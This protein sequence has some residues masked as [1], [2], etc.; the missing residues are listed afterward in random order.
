MDSSKAILVWPWDEAP[1][2]LKKIAS[3][4]GDEDW[5]IFVPKELVEEWLNRYGTPHWIERTAACCDPDR[6]D[7]P[8]GSVLYVGSHA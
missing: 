1:E 8:D 6:F 4:G 3:Q 2:D 5:L 7:L